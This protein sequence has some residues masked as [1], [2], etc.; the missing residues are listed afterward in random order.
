M[1]DDEIDTAIEFC[2]AE[3]GRV[4][5]N[6]TK[7]FREMLDRAIVKSKAIRQLAGNPERKFFSP[8][9]TVSDAR[10]GCCKKIKSKHYAD[11]PWDMNL[12]CEIGTMLTSLVKTAQQE[13]PKASEIEILRMVWALV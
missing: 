7:A 3:W 11:K 4:P 12:S 10:A 9:Q 6:V 5:E 8:E 2:K 13:N 1:T